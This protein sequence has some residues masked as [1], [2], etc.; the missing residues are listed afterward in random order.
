GADPGRRP[1]L[2]AF[3]DATTLMVPAPAYLQGLHAI[4]GADPKIEETRARWSQKPLVA[5]AAVEIRSKLRQ[6][7]WNHRRGVRA[8][9]HRHDAAAAR[10]GAEFASRKQHARR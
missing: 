2:V 6:V 4:F 7:D 9:H 3:I 5:I 1:I 8:V 10:F